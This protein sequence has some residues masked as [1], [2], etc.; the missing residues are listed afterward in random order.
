M[1]P[2]IVVL[3]PRVVA[4]LAGP[5]DRVER[6]DELAALRVERLDAAADAVLGAG[7]ARDDEPIVVERCARDRE[8]VLPALGLHRPRDFAGLLVERDELAV[9]L[10]DE[11]FAVA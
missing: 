7:E 3:R 10:A 9:E 5:G 4:E 1:H 8:P 2:E 6:P 11:H